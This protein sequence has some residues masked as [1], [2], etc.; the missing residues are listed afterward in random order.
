MSASGERSSEDERI[1]KLAHDL[2]TPL[3]IV[4]GFADLL[5]RRGADLPPDEVADFVE[6]IAEAAREMKEL[7]DAERDERLG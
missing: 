1:A 2:R 5:Q 7:L 4:S 6:R 3:T